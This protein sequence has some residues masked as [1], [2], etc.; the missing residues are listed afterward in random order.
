MTRCYPGERRPLDARAKRDMGAMVPSS[1]ACLG[2][3][4]ALFCPRKYRR[5]TTRRSSFVQTEP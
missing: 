3:I 2:C 4:P 5:A 1:A